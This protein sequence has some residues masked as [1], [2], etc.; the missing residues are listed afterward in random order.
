MVAFQLISLW[1][2]FQCLRQKIPET[3]R[4]YKAKNVENISI[5]SILLEEAA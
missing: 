4:I 1:V 5:L 3:Y 2:V